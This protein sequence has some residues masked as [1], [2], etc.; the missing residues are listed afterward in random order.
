VTA[1]RN[2]AIVMVLAYPF[3]LLLAASALRARLLEPRRLWQPP[4]LEPWLENAQP[5]PPI[6]VGRSL[7]GYPLYNPDTAVARARF[8]GVVAG[9]TLLL[10]G[11]PLIMAWRFRSMPFRR[12]SRTDPLICHLAPWLPRT[13]LILCP[14]YLAELLAAVYLGEVLVSGSVMYVTPVF[15]LPM[16]AGAIA[17]AFGFRG[18]REFETPPSRLNGILLRPE[19]QPDLFSLP[20]IGSVPIAATLHPS[21]ALLDGVTQCQE[22]VVNGPLLLVPLTLCRVLTKAEFLCLVAQASEPLAWPA[23]G[24]R[25]EEAVQ[26]VHQFRWRIIETIQSG[27]FARWAPG[28]LPALSLCRYLAEGRPDTSA[29]VMSPS[30]EGDRTTAAKLG[31]LDLARAMLKTNVCLRVWSSFEVQMG[32]DLTSG[33]TRPREYRRLARQFQSAI[34]EDAILTAFRQLEAD[35]EP[36]ALQDRLAR[37]GY[38]GPD[39][40]PKLDFSPAEPAIEMIRDADAIEQALSAAERALF[41]L[42]RPG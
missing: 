14:V 23:L 7:L 40:W 29:R 19:A 12:L 3:V 32:R 6:L 20:G 42:E 2:K 11:L 27:M 38:A 36:G 37:L 33:E 39:D 41:V 4:V 18:T 22:E 13:A 9:V 26:S 17:F 34:T 30:Y 15:A 16:A 5:P 25:Y 24:W 35:R 8:W 28:V 31:S 1:T 21:V 10:S